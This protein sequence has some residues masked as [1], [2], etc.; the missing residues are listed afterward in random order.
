MAVGL[1]TE[2]ESC[3]VGASWAGAGHESVVR[4]LRGSRAL[5]E[6]ARD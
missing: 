2:V 6:R 1:L 4:E 3:R 5:K